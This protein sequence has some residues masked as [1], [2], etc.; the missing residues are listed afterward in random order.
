MDALLIGGGQ[1][2]QKV[3]PGIGASTVLQ[4]KLRVKLSRQYLDHCDTIR[5]CAT[6]PPTI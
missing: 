5:V 1:S 3:M 4:Q 2:G 6:S